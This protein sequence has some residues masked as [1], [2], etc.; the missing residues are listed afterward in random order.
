MVGFPWANI[1]APGK[2]YEE[3]VSFRKQSPGSASRAW[4]RMWAKPPVSPP[5]E[6]PWTPFECLDIGK[7]K[8]SY[9][10]R[11]EHC[12]GHFRSLFSLFGV[13]NK[14]VCDA[15]VSRNVHVSVH[16]KGTKQG[17]AQRKQSS[18]TLVMFPKRGS[19]K[20]QERC[21]GLGRCQGINS[22][23]SLLA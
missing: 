10:W 14:R 21:R 2:E 3:S 15:L 19:N 12:V 9:P 22:Q 20:C 18:L 11:A 16:Y 7:K 8:S 23:E 17:L 6:W 1:S 5:W 13:K 4:Q